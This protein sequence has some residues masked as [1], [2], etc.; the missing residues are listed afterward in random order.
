M[1]ANNPKRQS[2][3]ATR[4]F[5]SHALLLIVF[6]AMG[7][8][9]I[10]RTGQLSDGPTAVRQIY[11]P[12]SDS[13]AQ[14]NAEHR[15]FVRDTQLLFD[16]TDPRVQAYLIRHARDG[17]ESDSS[18]ARALDSARRRL[19]RARESGSFS[20]GR[21]ARDLDTVGN[22]L[23]SLSETEAELRTVALDLLGLL[24]SQVA[25]VIQAFEAEDERDATARDIEPTS[26]ALDL[27]PTATPATATGPSSARRDTRAPPLD[28]DTDDDALI[29]PVALALRQSVIQEKRARMESLQR[30]FA[31]KLDGLHARL[32]RSSTYVLARAGRE[33]DSFIIGLAA[34][35]VFGAF[36]GLFMMLSTRRALQPLRTLSVAARRIAAGD[37]TVKP[38]REI[39]VGGEVAELA[40]DFERMAAALDDRE[41]QLRDE[42]RRTAEAVRGMQRANLDLTSLKNYNENIVRSIRLGLVAADADLY[43]TSM[44]PAAEAL[45]STRASEMLGKSVTLL[46]PDHSILASRQKLTHAI[47]EG[48]VVAADGVAPWGAS[49]SDETTRRLDVTMVPLRAGDGALSGVLLIADDVTERLAMRRRMLQSERFAAIGKLSAQVVHEVRNPLNSI[50]LN[51]EVLADDIERLARGEADIAEVRG[52]LASIQREVTR[53]GTVTEQYL[54]YARLPPPSLENEDLNT[55]IRDLL[56]FLQGEFVARNVRVD[57]EYDETLTPIAADADQVRQA[58][59]NIVRNSTEAMPEGGLIRLRTVSEKPFAVIEIADNGCGMSAETARRI[60]DP[61]YSTKRD[62][63]GLGLSLTRQIIETHGGE[64]ECESKEGKGTTFTVR[65][66]FAT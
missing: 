31:R 38:A 36:V 8:F 25:S 18:M 44:N 20:T 63:T 21:P 29:D 3:I 6:A 52:I 10:I 17:I 13:L 5:L 35:T 23:Q 53:L 45:F 43:I 28:D 15:L 32:E 30:D 9:A 37:Y 19:A 54:S 50:G 1:W 47:A 51:T 16:A 2:S 66:P 57:A 56:A 58:L 60:F 49:A 7:I 48:A 22:E 46:V 40:A 12:L 33:S 42:Q 64:I 4:V 14:A 62:G 27:E 26:V 65:L 11:G 39:N 41:A 55:L 24:E 34:F 59:L 61:F